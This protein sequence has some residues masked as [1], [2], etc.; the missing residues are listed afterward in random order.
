M[1]GMI[2]WMVAM[3]IR[4][5]TGTTIVNKRLA[6]AELKE[7]P[8]ND[9]AN[10]DEMTAQIADD[11]ATGFAAVGIMF[12]LAPFA[13][14]VFRGMNAGIRYF[15]RPIKDVLG[16]V[17]NIIGLILIGLQLLFFF[18]NLLKSF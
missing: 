8:F 17:L 15:F 11:A 14:L 3:F 5:C 12:V 7:P 13:Y 1:G 16:M 9:P 2:I 4:A 18:I 10:T 6:Q